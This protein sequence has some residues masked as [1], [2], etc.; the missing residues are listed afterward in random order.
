MLVRLCPESA[1]ILSRMK[2]GGKKTYKRQPTVPTRSN[3]RLVGIDVD[4][5]VSRRATTSIA[6]HNP[7]VRPPHGLL[8]NELDSCIWSRLCPA[9]SVPPLVEKK[10]NAS[11]HFALLLRPST[12]FNPKTTCNWGQNSQQGEHQRNAPAAQNPSA[13]TAGPSWPR[14]AAAASVTRYRHGLAPGRRPWAPAP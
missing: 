7:L 3:L 2:T 12:P 14:R 1:A 6:R 13:R 8:V 9:S 11:R 5:G 4:L 10:I